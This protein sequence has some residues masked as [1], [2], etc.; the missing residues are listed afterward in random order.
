MGLFI[1]KACLV[2]FLIFN[3]AW[4][5]GDELDFDQLLEADFEELMNISVVTP[6]RR[7]QRL[8]RVTVSTSVL[9]QQ[10]IRQS[11]V[12]SLPEALRLMPGVIVREMASGHYDVHIR[13]LDSV[14]PNKGYPDMFNKS[15]LVMIDHR[16]VYNYF[17]GAV[18]W[19]ELP[20]ELHDLARIEL[21]RGS[22]GS[23]YGANAAS[24]VIHFITQDAFEEANHVSVARGEHHSE[25]LRARF[26]SKL[27]DTAAFSGSFH[28]SQRDRSDD[29]YYSFDALGYRPLASVNSL[30]TDLPLTELDKRY[31]DQ[32][33]SLDKQGLNLFL[34][35]TPA[36]GQSLRLSAGLAHSS[37]QS[38]FHDSRATPLG[39]YKSQHQ[40]LSAVYDSQALHWAG[41]VKQGELV[42][43]SVMGFDF[44]YQVYDT[45][46][47]HKTWS[48]GTSSLTLGGAL[49]GTE[50]KS[51]FLGHNGKADQFNSALFSQ[52]HHQLHSKLRVTAAVR[53]DYFETPND[54]FW[55]FSGGM[56][57]QISDD[58]NGRAYLGR[59]YQSP[60][61]IETNVNADVMPSS[62][63]RLKF[64]GNDNMAL[65]TI[66][67][68]EVGFRYRIREGHNLDWELFVMQADSY[69]DI[70][71]DISVDN[72]VVVTDSKFETLR[73]KARIIGSTLSWQSSWSSQ[74]SSHVYVTA[75][76]TDLNDAPTFTGTLEDRHHK[77]TPTYYGG[78]VVNYRPTAVWNW[79]VNAYYLD[80]QAFDYR[81]LDERTLDDS[82]YQE[83]SRWILNTKLSYQFHRVGRVFINGR[84]LVNSRQPQLQY[85]DRLDSLWMAGVELDF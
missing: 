25:D 70:E 36:A 41:S 12:T 85:M 80:E 21:V 6:G 7:A 42:A 52:L 56:N 22:S 84:N 24:G 32:R 77:G 35:M 73:L 51:G 23:L 40:Y 34:D 17:N 14:P 60:F 75:Q 54:V 2:A 3:T 15:A 61:F 31:P 4:L 38:V 79:N 66:E 10:Q 82:V 9:T 49:S 72:G 5:H 58:L 33:L 29:Q 62:N 64:Q 67:S 59:A 30:V 48:D 26:S 13:G 11:G 81:M 8:S 53:G 71:T 57:Y 18:I 44:D 46:L 55:S 78:V 20:I 50:Y 83:D 76:N 37:Y 63:R 27:S 45:T 47:E 69:P 68:G 28:R 43:L 1:L 65:T 74:V 16:P 39:S 19:Q